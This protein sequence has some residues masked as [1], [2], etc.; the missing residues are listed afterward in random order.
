MGWH[1]AFIPRAHTLQ[2]SLVQ[3]G[4]VS[5]SKRPP[6]MQ[7]ARLL[8]PTLRVGVSTSPHP[9]PIVGTARPHCHTA[10]GDSVNHLMSWSDWYSSKKKSDWY[11]HLMQQ[12][13]RWNVQCFGNIRSPIA[14][15]E[16]WRRLVSWMKKRSW[17]W[18]HQA[19][20]SLDELVSHIHRNHH[21]AKQLIAGGPAQLTMIGALC[22][23]ANEKLHPD[24][25]LT[26]K[27]TTYCWSIAN[28]LLG[29]VAS[30]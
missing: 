17:T 6:N 28:K 25:N 4:H 24:V 11:C 8:R 15:S 23:L 21:G 1:A 30:D 7:D 20:P 9:N 12:H 27:Y 18:E 2:S 14:W 10:T 29:K 16:D 5:G 19:W 22:T 3:A 13:L 26:R